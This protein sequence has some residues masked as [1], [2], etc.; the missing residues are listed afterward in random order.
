LLSRAELQ[1]REIE[2]PPQ[3]LSFLYE[4]SRGPALPFKE[5]SKYVRTAC[6]IDLACQNAFKT[7]TLDAFTEAADQQQS[8][9]RVSSSTLVL[10]FHGAF[11]SLARL[12][13]VR[14]VPRGLLMRRA[15][16]RDGRTALFGA[17]RSLQGGRSIL[18]APD[19]PYGTRSE[20]LRVLGVK[21]R[22]ADSAAFL[23]YATNCATAWYTVVRR[24]E[25]FAVQL[26]S[27][28]AKQDGEDFAGFSLRLEEFYARQI[29]NIFSGDPKNISL[30][31]NWRRTFLD[32]LNS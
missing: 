23:A 22:M 26:E 1:A 20:R 29:E 7:K 18:L 11:V 28:P 4:R 16:A 6:A 2:I 3:L 10:T 5:W 15:D 12:A 21:A 30:R 17:L 32:H 25:E 31:P 27:G 19:G 13:F 8:L 9:Q 24:G 14:Q